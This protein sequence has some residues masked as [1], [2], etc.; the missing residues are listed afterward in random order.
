MKQNREIKKRFDIYRR[1]WLDRAYY[2]INFE[3]GELV[4]IKEPLEERRTINLK[5]LDTL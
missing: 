4:E 1:R 2:L 3:T 5:L